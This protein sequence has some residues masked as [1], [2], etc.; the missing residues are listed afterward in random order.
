MIC[1]LGYN[2]REETCPRAPCVDCMHRMGLGVAKDI[3]TLTSQ[4][5]E[6]CLKGDHV[7]FRAL[8]LIATNLG[9]LLTRHEQ[10]LEVAA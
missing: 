6:A 7:A 2:L 10:K 4:R 9:A 8:D 3:A 1:A 5:R